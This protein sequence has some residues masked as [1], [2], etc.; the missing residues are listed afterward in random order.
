M[1]AVGARHVVA[2]VLTGA[3]ARVLIERATAAAD[4]RPTDGAAGALALVV[5][6]TEFA[7]VAVAILRALGLVVHGE[8][9]RQRRARREQQERGR[10][11]GNARKGSESTAHLV[12]EQAGRKRSPTEAKYAN[13]PGKIPQS[14]GLFAAR[15]MA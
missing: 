12:S 5:L 10:R 2:Q 15:G 13:P 1:N 6:G 4:E 9:P 3:F 7:V 11:S 14:R 8:A